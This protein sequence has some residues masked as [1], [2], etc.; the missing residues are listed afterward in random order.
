MKAII[1]IELEIDGQ[2]LKTDKD[3]LIDRIMD[4]ASAGLWDIDEDRLIVIQ[5]SMTCRLVGRA[6]EIILNL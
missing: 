1:E 6:E 4:N 2:W 5:R 3:V